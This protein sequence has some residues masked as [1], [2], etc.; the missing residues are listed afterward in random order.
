MS[1]FPG[2]FL[3]KVKQ[4]N[5]QSDLISTSSFAGPSY[6][7]VWSSVCVILIWDLCICKLWQTESSDIRRKPHQQCAL[8]FNEQITRVRFLLLQPSIRPILAQVILLWKGPPNF[9]SNVTLYPCE[10]SRQNHLAFLSFKY[11]N[12]DTYF[13]WHFRSSL[14]PWQF[15]FTVND[16]GYEQQSCCW[17]YSPCCRKIQINVSTFSLLTLVRKIWMH[18]GEFCTIWLISHTVQFD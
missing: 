16:N 18:E 2:D 9:Q 1:S 11:V 15:F 12:T 3:T 6:F 8:N 17:L 13:Y 4:I 10:R 5:S 14:R 7:T